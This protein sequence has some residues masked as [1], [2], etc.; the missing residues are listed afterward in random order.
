MKGFYW[1]K[2]TEKGH[3]KQ[4]IHCFGQG[5]LP[6]GSRKV[7]LRV[8]YLTS[9]DRV[10]PDWLKVTFLA[11]AVTSVRLSTRSCFVDW[12]HS[13]SDSI[14]GCFSFNTPNHITMAKKLI[15]ISSKENFINVSINEI[16]FQSNLTLRKK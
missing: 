5:H 14:W 7:L 6:L 11:E 9:A 8:D 4:R 3:F 2:G 16:L 1:Q 10:I 15:Y 13:T 12:G